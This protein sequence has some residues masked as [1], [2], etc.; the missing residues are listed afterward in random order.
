MWQTGAP[1][2]GT[3]GPNPALKPPSEEV[4]AQKTAPL[5]STNFMADYADNTAPRALKVEDDQGR[6]RVVSNFKQGFNGKGAERYESGETYVG[7]FANAKR[8][9]RGTYIDEDGSQ[10]VSLFNKGNPFGEGA[11]VMPGGELMRTHGGK[12]DGAISM[13]D[14]VEI[15]K[16]S[17]LPPPPENWSPAPQPRKREPL[18]KPAPTDYTTT[19]QA[20]MSAL[21]VDY[22]TQPLPRDAFLAKLE[23]A[24]KSPPKNDRMALIPRVS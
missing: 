13:E 10:L 6:V 5:P 11:K 15:A 17:L 2:E 9:G 8:H 12:V 14:A 19:A 4:L 22:V 20:Q 16:H 23:A 21:A 3:A 1:F 18:P 7:E 24:E